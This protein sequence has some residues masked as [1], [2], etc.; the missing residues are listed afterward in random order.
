[1][2]RRLVASTLLVALAGLLVLG[3]PLAFL[4]VRY[5]QANARDDLQAEANRIA[6]S[7][8]ADPTTDPDELARRAGEDRGVTLDGPSGRIEAGRPYSDGVIEVSAPVGADG[9]L[10]LWEPSSNWTGAAT[11][12]LGLLA[13]L[14]LIGLLASTALGWRFAVR[15]GAA[16]DELGSVARR[17]GA[18]DFSARAGRSGIAEIDDIA[19]A[20]DHSAERIGELVARERRF[21]AD[22]S[23]QLRTPL[24]ALSLRLEELRH[25]TDPDEVRAEADAGLAQVDR[26]MATVEELLAHARTGQTGAARDVDLADLVRTHLARWRP[27]FAPRDVRLRIEASTGPR[28]MV[29]ASPGAVSQAIDV[30]LDN[31]L[32]HGAGRVDLEV[33]SRGDH[34][35]VRVTDEGPGVDPSVGPRLFE[36]GV[37]TDGTGIGLAL[38]QDLLAAD[39]GRIELV[40]A[41]P[42]TFELWLPGSV[43]A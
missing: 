41:K 5:S 15:I 23:H 1:M 18:G 31:A 25:L 43:E 33:R 8:A 35:T 20:L 16:T 11:V 36:R 19:E 42:A 38:A 7:L 32:R 22:A 6:T 14:G 39:G 17:L 10:T 9:L 37:T 13:V 24:T 30:L 4:S 28:H 40:R 3:T 27:L 26:L 12:Q 2:R 21:S 34:A 29:R